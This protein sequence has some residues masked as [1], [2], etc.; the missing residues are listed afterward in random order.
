MTIFNRRCVK[1][2]RQEDSGSPHAMRNELNQ[3]SC[4]RGM[5]RPLLREKHM[6]LSRCEVSLEMIPRPCREVQTS[7]VDRP[8]VPPCFGEVTLLA[9]HLATQGRMSAFPHQIR[10]VRGHFS[11]YEPSDFLVLLIGSAISA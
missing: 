2:K 9:Q 1:C 5:K 10:L 3:V 6:P 8:S 11:H 7:A 4:G